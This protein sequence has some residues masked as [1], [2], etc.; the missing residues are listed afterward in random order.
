M[1]A[2]FDGTAVRL[3]FEGLLKPGSKVHEPRTEALNGEAEPGQQLRI[4]ERALRLKRQ[5]EL[6]EA[7]ELLM[8]NGLQWVPKRTA[9]SSTRMVMNP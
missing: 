3:L 2:H 4:A 7:K 6:D 5:G 9:L 1:R 8:F